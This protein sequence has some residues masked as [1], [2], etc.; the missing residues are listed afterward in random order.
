M[1]QNVNNN[2]DFR[3]K[4]RRFVVL[5]FVKLRDLEQSPKDFHS[6]SIQNFSYFKEFCFD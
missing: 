1:L 6:R 5:E 2:I 3:G 4:I